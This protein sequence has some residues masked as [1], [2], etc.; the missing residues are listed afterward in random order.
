MD[1]LIF[2]INEMDK[3]KCSM[4]NPYSRAYHSVQTRF[5]REL[6][7]FG[8]KAKTDEELKKE[9]A[10]GSYKKPFTTFVMQLTTENAY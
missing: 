7:W 1:R 5:R 6:G 9:K 10:K 3:D 4:K 8:D 2:L